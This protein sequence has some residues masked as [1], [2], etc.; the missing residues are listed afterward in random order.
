MKSTYELSRE[1]IKQA[2]I[3][4]VV[5]KGLAQAGSISSVFIHVEPELDRMDRPTGTMN[6]TAKV[7][8][9]VKP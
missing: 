7:S 8:V 1:E 5:S 2:L 4:H 6:V 3:D 9:E